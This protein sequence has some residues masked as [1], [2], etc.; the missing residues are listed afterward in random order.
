VANG[1]SIG[2]VSFSEADANYKTLR[3][4]YV[5][6]LCGAL[7]VAQDGVLAMITYKVTQ[8]PN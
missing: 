3:L 1:T 5:N 4:F 7:Q 8:D 6:P 2:A